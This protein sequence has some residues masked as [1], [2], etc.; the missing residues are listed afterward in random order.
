V[1][2]PVAQN[3]VASPQPVATS[4]QVVTQQPV[5]QPVTAPVKPSVT[6]GKPV[7]HTAS[8]HET[9]EAKA[10]RIAARYGIH[11]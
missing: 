11:W 10:R 1:Q 5:T 2:A 8:R 4:Q 9:D 7:V 3:Q 6:S